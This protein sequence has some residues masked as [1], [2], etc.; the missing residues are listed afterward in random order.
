MALAAGAVADLSFMFLVIE[1][2]GAQSLPGRKASG[3]QYLR[4][5]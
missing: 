3:R 5:V 2:F 1:H 4:F